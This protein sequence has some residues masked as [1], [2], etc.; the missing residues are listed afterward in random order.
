MR[1][2]TFHEVGMK[3]F[4]PYVEPMVLTFENDK[5]TLITGPNGIGKTMS[6]EA[7]PFTL[8]GETCKKA[9]GDDVVN[10]RTGRNCHT[11]VKFSI[12][13]DNYQIDRYHKYTKLQNTVTISKNGE[14]PY[15]KG[16]REV[17][18]EVEK[19][20]CSKKSFMNTLMFGQK[21]KDFF[22]DL[23]DS[24]KKEIFRKILDLDI[25]TTWYKEA[26]ADLKAIKESL[27]K[28]VEQIGIERGILSDVEF[29]I[30]ILFKQFSQFEENKKE[31]VTYMKK[32]IE[33]SRRILDNWNIER[34]K[35][36]ATEHDVEQL[37][38]Q[39]ND[40]EKQIDHHEGEKTTAMLQLSHSA[41]A[42]I[43]EIK[44]A[45]SKATQTLS[46]KRQKTYEVLYE[47]NQ[48]EMNELEGEQNEAQEGRNENAQK[49]ASLATEKRVCQNDIDNLNNSLEID[50][51]VCP[52]CLQDI[53]DKCRDHL[54]KE[55]LEAI[56]RYAEFERQEKSIQKS[57]ETYQKLL[58]QN[59]ERRYQQSKQFEG[60]RD[61]LTL[62]EMK[63]KKEIEVKVNATIEKINGLARDET[64]KIERDYDEYISK[65]NKKLDQLEG[66]KEVVFNTAEKIKEIDSTISNLVQNITGMELQLK[67]AEEDE[68]DKSQ[69]AAYQMRKQQLELAIEELNQGV[70]ILQKD[71]VL[72]TFW[73][74]AW[75]PTGI[76]SMLIDESIPFMNE[77]V[78]DYLDL[79]T[80]GRYIVSFDTLAATKAG[81]F[82]DK[83]SVNVLDTHTRANSRIQLSGGQTRIVDIATILTLG[84]L[85]SSI[86]DVNINIL[87]FD[88][89]FDSL[90]E[91]NIG[92][93]SNILSQLKVGKSIYL[94]SHTQ[95][96][97]LEADEILELK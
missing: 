36:D 91:E 2:I 27:S 32:S 54:E 61:S 28:I 38:S 95:V 82:R 16:H 22:T 50:G 75:S 51:G 30:D 74:A 65:L 77:K 7:I 52:T 24:D 62:D 69:L 96:D 78:S 81:E 45:A 87:L 43:S 56:N 73:K 5:L 72:S 57:Q 42:K 60:A 92:F 66:I 46:E 21:V 44:E 83:I 17:V 67:M 14:D 3:N 47:S 89:I 13:S 58:D 93:V 25:Y 86:Q 76:P 53:D 37:Q 10:T 63:E 31:K 49:L 20:I 18:P 33:D 34:E 85:Q 90:D 80:N 23:I 84:D 48:N 97:Q 8:Y 79:L 29:Q 70:V 68:Y 26:D 35:L 4:G 41:S 39:I 40:V 71:E 19:L 59:A 12:D 15:M 11:W 1:E 9:R 88:E 64:L 94:I 55:V 6:L